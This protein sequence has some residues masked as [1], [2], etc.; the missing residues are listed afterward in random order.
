MPELPEVETICRGIAPHVHGK[1]VARLII[2]DARLRWPVADELCQL[3]ASQTILGVD[4]RAKYLLFRTGA[5]TLLSHLGMTG[6]FRVLS[7][8]TP[9]DKHDHVDLIFTDGSLLRYTDARRFGSLHWAGQHPE[10]HPLLRDLGPEPFD[11]AF[12]GD[13]LHQRS[14]QKKQPVKLFLMDN[15]V[16]VG[17][18]NIYANEA[19]FLAGI[20]PTRAAGRV[21]LARYCRLRDAAVQVL[22]SAIQHGGTTLRDYVD[23][24][25]APG[26]FRVHLNVY[27]RDDQPCPRCG[28][29]IRTIR[30]GQRSTFYCQECQR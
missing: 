29:A 15:H 21:S 22:E 23:S 26:Y 27:G 14:R 12:S 16:V 3:L 2:R 1:V 11:P 20:S 6:K 9:P 8:P 19:L 24:R 10:T 30:L 18:G 28:S 13:Y 7:Q 5:G 4:R 25:G 17:L